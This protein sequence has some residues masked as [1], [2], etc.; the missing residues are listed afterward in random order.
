[1]TKRILRY[2]NLAFTVPPGDMA[3]K[4]RRGFHAFRKRRIALKRPTYHMDFV[5][6]GKPLISLLQPIP[7]RALEPHRRL[8]SALAHHY[9][10]HRFD[11]LGSGWVQVRQGM[12]CR[13]ERDPVN[14]DNVSGTSP[15]ECDPPGGEINAANAQESGRIR[16]LVDEDYV[17][18]DWHRD[19]KSGFRW[20]QDTWY[21]EIRYGAHQGVDIKVPWDLSRM[22]HLPLL[23]LAYAL[24][25]HQG[26]KESAEPRSRRY[27]R[28]FR[29]QVLDFMAANPPSFGVN[30][31]SSMDAAIRISNWLA[32]YDLFSAYGEQFDED[33][34]SLL[35]RSAFE[36]ARHIMNN[37]EYSYDFRGN[38]YLANVV[39]LLFAGAYVQRTPETDVWLAFG[40]QELVT[41]VQRQF[42]PDGMNF[43]ASTSYHRLSLEMA[44]YGT[45]LVLGLPDRKLAA[46]REYDSA[47][48]RVRPGL[49]PN[50][51][52]LHP[53][54]GSN[55]KTP[56]PA[57]YWHRLEKAVEASARIM[58]PD[59]HVPQIGDNDNGRFFRLLPT[60]HSMLV[61]RAK[62][63]YVN[64]AGYEEMPVDGEYLLEDHLDHR[65]L[66]HAFTGL[67]DP[68]DAPALP[69]QSFE[70]EIVR[71]YAAGATISRRKRSLPAIGCH[72]KTSRPETLESGGLLSGLSI[73]NYPDFGLSVF[74]S[75]RLHLCVRCGPNGQN[76]RGGHS[77]NDQLSFELWVDGVPIVVDS[78]TYCYTSFVHTRNL[79]R[80]TAMHNTLALES[81][82][83]NS[84][85]D[86]LAGTFRLTDKA[87]AEVRELGQDIFTG[88]HFGFKSPHS[89]TIRILADKIQGLDEL[90]AVGEKRMFFHLHPSVTI[91]DTHPQD[92]I[93]MHS[94]DVSIAFQ[95]GPGQWECKPGL[96]SPG[97]GVV[98]HN[99]T[100]CL[101]SSS[102]RIDWSIVVS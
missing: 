73:S 74:R 51:Q 21:R 52:P 39:G 90:N 3:Y 85:E 93:V 4:I 30:W 59:G 22:Q 25:A 83:Q 65:H 61:G 79:F 10:S 87:H 54:P 76:G 31:A 63:T 81:K 77:H 94:G 35:A 69:S 99:S 98:Q 43:E 62:E 42:F 12:R 100:L 36:H 78:G 40:V 33:F 38:H 71:S 96:Y 58:T 1:M 80:S 23:G 8:L 47:L 46:L 50:P 13:G 29:N 92:G 48:H 45:A 102:T 2:L 53:L 67:L 34:R 14:A 57:G 89:R 88:R 95:G 68:R 15:W 86:G 72:A 70:S 91:I 64:L 7:P 5:V 28:E 49:S 27:A 18:I 20:K 17:P 9:V 32:A 97:Y 60:Y 26:R 6:P 82:E 75:P 11:L 55:R 24:A 84:W 44:L 19:F 37:L 101:V 66:L 41:E 56:F 16:Q